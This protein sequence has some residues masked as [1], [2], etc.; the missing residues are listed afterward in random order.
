[1]GYYKMGILPNCFLLLLGEAFNYL[2]TNY[3]SLG[4][5]H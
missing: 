2:L 3:D 1:M 4:K 5:I